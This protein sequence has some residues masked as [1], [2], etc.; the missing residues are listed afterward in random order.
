MSDTRD[1]VNEAIRANR[2]LLARLQV[3]DDAVAAEIAALE[4][5]RGTAQG[6][7]HEVLGAKRDELQQERAAIASERQ[8]ALRELAALDKLHG[9]LPAIEAQ[10]LAR[11]A[12]AF[13][14]VD[15]DA[16]PPPARRMSEEEA[17]AQ[18]VA[19]KAQRTGGGSGTASSPSSSSSSSSPP[20]P[21]SSPS[22]ADR[23]PTP[24]DDAPRKRTL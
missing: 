14:G 2:L 18:L 12:L 10:T 9:K 6:E 20:S 13:A 11:E 16:P 1:S 7:L 24:P 15:P 4:T 22:D 5:E 8:D 21:S 23:E 19:L 17:R 3:R